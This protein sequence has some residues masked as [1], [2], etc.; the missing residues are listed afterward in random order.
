MAACNPLFLVINPVVLKL[1]P[2]GT[3]WIIICLVENVLLH[4]EEY[5]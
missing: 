4:L 2:Y 3:H 1:T 5:L